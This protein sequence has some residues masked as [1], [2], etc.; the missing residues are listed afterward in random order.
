MREV[1]KKVDSSNL[2]QS[3]RQQALEIKTGLCERAQGRILGVCNRR[4]R[5][6][7][8]VFSPKANAK[9]VENA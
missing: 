3:S 6:A 2:N 9:W 1:K 8:A 5:E 4:A 7:I